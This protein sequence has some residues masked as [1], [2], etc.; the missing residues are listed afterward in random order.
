MNVRI[1]KANSAV[2][3]AIGREGTVW[4]YLS[5]KD[6]ESIISEGNEVWFRALVSLWM[7]LLF[8]QLYYALD[9]DEIL[10]VGSTVVDGEVVQMC[11]RAKP[12]AN[13]L[14]VSEVLRE[15]P[16]ADWKSVKKMGRK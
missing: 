16:K 6:A 10:V 13:G 15:I 2:R 3:K 11:F 1:W 5:E 4:F 9:G 8:D 7:K 14:H 12:D